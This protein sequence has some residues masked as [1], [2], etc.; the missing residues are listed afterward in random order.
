M[1]IGKVSLE[2]WRVDHGNR[3]V[4]IEDLVEIGHHKFFSGS[5]LNNYISPRLTEEMESYIHLESGL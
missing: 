1:R 4:S 2:T 5:H 3:I